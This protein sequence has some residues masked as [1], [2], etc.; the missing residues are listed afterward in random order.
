MM[1][2]GFRYACIAG[3]SFGKDDLII[4][5]KPKSKLVEAA[6]QKVKE[7]EQQYHGRTY[8]QG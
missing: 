8:H 2:L 5:E 3:I 7:F 1:K 4:P 6:K